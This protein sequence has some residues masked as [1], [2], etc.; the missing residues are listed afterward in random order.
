MKCASLEFYRASDLSMYEMSFG[1]PTIWGHLEA[2][3]LINLPSDF[4]LNPTLLQS[5][6]VSRSAS[7]L[8]SQPPPCCAG[9]CQGGSHPR[10]YCL[11]VCQEFWLQFLQLLWQKTKSEEGS[12][13]MSLFWIV[14]KI[15]VANV[16]ISGFVPSLLLAFEGGNSVLPQNIRGAVNCLRWSWLS[17]YTHEINF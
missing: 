6:N 5:I 1:N 13:Q 15:I 9:F 14:I 16:T 12:K 4:A 17:A 11:W 7:L 10:W 3:Y 2:Q 8:G